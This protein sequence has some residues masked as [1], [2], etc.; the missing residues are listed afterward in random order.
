MQE[1]GAFPA[2]AKDLPGHGQFTTLA[3]VLQTQLLNA[4]IPIAEKTGID[5]FAGDQALSIGEPPRRAVRLDGTDGGA[6]SAALTKLG[7]KPQDALGRHFLAIGEEGG[8]D[9]KS[10]LAQLGVLSELDRAV[11]DG[12]TVAWGAFEAPV[13][14]AL[15]GSGSSLA[16][17]PSYAAAADCLGDVVTASCCPRALPGSTG[18]RC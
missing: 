6:F 18:R 16:D 11:V 13:D 8:F 4:A 10:P 12:D 2:H 14:E 9:V 15:G 3:G 17:N 1:D 7:A 5:V